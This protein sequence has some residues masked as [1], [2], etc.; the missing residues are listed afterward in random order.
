LD[1]VTTRRLTDQAAFQVPYRSLAMPAIFILQSQVRAMIPIFLP[2]QYL[3]SPLEEVLRTTQAPT[4]RKDRIV[5]R[6]THM[7][8]RSARRQLSQSLAKARKP[9]SRPTATSAKPLLCIVLALHKYLSLLILISK[10]RNQP[11]RRALMRQ[12]SVKLIIR[13]D[14]VKH[15]R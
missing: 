9:R 10:Q 12:V 13:W 3:A 2:Y 4:L 14:K 11:I 15:I 6:S 7:D 5:C 1:T 8:T